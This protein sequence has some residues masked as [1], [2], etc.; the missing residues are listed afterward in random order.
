MKWIVTL[1]KNGTPLFSKQLSKQLY[2]C[3]IVHWTSDCVT[4]PNDT[5]TLSPC[6]G[7]SK[8]VPVA[9]TKWRLTDVTPLCIIPKLSPLRS[10]I[11]PMMQE[12]IRHNTTS[13][14]SHLTWAD[15]DDIV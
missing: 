6:P 3:K 12:R 10:L 14:T 7:C 11:L 13:I 9:H 1:D 8:H 4:R 5:I 15:I 2:A